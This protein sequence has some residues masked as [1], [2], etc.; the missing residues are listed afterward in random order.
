MFKRILTILVI[1][2]SLCSCVYAAEPEVDL[3]SIENL[4][5]KLQQENYIPEISFSN[6]I[7]NYKDTGEVGFSIK[8]F[9]NSLISYIFREITISSKLMV[10]LLFI[11]MLCAVFENVQRSFDDNNVSKIAYYSCFLVMVIIIIKSFTN[12]V[13][14][15]KNAITQMIEF[16]NAL[17]PILLSLLA[18]TG[19]FASAAILDPVIMVL[20]KIISDVIRDIVLPLTILVVILKIVD[21]LSDEIKI[22][23]LAALISQINGWIIG[24]IMTVFIG[25][26][27]IRG[28]ASATIDQVTL[29]SAKFA[30]DNFIPVVGKCLSDAIG[31]VV[32]YS[33]ILK[34]AISIAGLLFIIFI[35]LFP[36]IKI[37]M[38]SLIYKFV[39]AV[40][41]PVVDKK[42]VDCLNAA[43][44]SMVMVFASVLSVAIM[45]FIMITIITSTGKLITIVR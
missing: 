7:K 34:D 24:F 15:G 3:S 37:I 5:K 36:L 32:S 11:G 8:N 16:T 41:E 2:F 43:G 21:N 1:I 23:R 13:D 35:C 28:S 27:T 25:F 42:I 38:L 19:G 22:T 6:M 44:N 45:F 39:G 17:I 9:W 31:T 4:S 30:M 20:I 40:M 14:I 33:L 12:A 18:S 26:V 29:K 10:E